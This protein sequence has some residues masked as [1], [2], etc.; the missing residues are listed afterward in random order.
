MSRHGY[1]PNSRPLSSWRRVVYFGAAALAALS[2]PAAT[3]AFAATLKNAPA[4]NF[5]A[6]RWLF[7]FAV[8]VAPLAVWAVQTS[9]PVDVLAILGIP[10]LGLLTGVALHIDRRLLKP[11]LIVGLALLLILTFS[12]HQ[13][14]R[15]IFH[16]YPQATINLR[17]I[18]IA[19]GTAVQRVS[20]GMI[21]SSATGSAPYVAA[22]RAWDVTPGADVLLTA[23]IRAAPT[24]SRFCQSSG[25]T[26]AGN[27]V[28]IQ[29]D[30]LGRSARFEL[31]TTPTTA[32]QTVN[33]SVPAHQLGDAFHV[34]SRIYLNECQ[35]IDV[36]SVQ[37]TSVGG[38]VSAPIVRSRISWPYGDPNLLAHM[39]LAA[40]VATAVVA[41]TSKW[42]LATGYLITL[43]LAVLAGSRTV[44]ILAIIP[45]LA[46]AT[47]WGRQRSGQWLVIAIVVLGAG[48]GFLVLD[49]RSQV[50]EDTLSRAQILGSF[51]DLAT[52]SWLTGVSDA[53]LATFR[54]DNPPF[55]NISHAH[56]FWLDEFVNYG[57]AGLLGSLAL[58][59]MLMLRFTRA[60]GFVGLLLLLPILLLN[61]LDSTLFHPSVFMYVILALNLL[62]AGPGTTEPLRYPH[63]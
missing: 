60:G 45:M 14:E 27:P 10:A 54:S 59:L 39:A 56:N 35:S 16:A 37:L 5:R 42:Y 53:D 24:P 46:I 48:A 50:L 29:L 28:R 62:E 30:W 41:G 63:S 26:P 34:I 58:T 47:T 6:R 38:N 21:D 43:A 18:D 44:P 7:T 36:R 4:A 9:N 1:S 25:T 23:R 51:Y 49:A 33:I 22:R 40:F 19:S 32:W 12:W 31:V 8:Y 17:G 20:Y 2:P 3:A 55:E 57:V 52:N 15:H 61:V 13:F 11:G